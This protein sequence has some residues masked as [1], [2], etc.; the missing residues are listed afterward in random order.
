MKELTLYLNDLT[1]GQ[2]SM[3]RLAEYLRA[4]ATLYGHEE[5]VHFDSVKPGSAQLQSQIDERAYPGVIN[6][7]REVSG[8]L[9]SKRAASA[10]DR[11]STLM[12]EDKTGAS[13]RSGGAQIFQF[14]VVKTDEPPMRVIKPSSIQGKLYSV[15]GKDDTIPVR[16]EGADNETLH[17][18]TG[19]DVAERLAQLLFKPVRVSGDG[20]WERKPD[21]SWKLIKLK[22]TS[23]TKLEDIGFKEAIA[24]LKAAGGVDW[25]EN[26]SAH[27]EILDTRG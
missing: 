9:G 2:L 16:I 23:F 6:Q 27:S 25:N 3:K 10:F 17:C 24:R 18:E 8:G 7:V 14:P 1:P 21:G 15:G 5:S 19:I 11:L 20:E 26:S 13:L 4:L 12:A 22:I